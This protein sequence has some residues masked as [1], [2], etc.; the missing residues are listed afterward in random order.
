MSRDDLTAGMQTEVQ[1][2]IIRPVWI[3]RLDIVGD[4]VLA[5]TG[6][7]PFSPVGTGD[8]ALDGNTFVGLGNLGK[9]S[10]IKDEEKGSS[11][12]TLT[13]PGVDLNLEALRQVVLNSNT[14]QFR[15][16]WIWFGLLNET[17]GVI[18]NPTRLKT[19]RIDQMLVNSS[20]DEGSVSVVLESFQSYAAQP[21]M[22]RYVEQKEI[23]ATDKSQ[24]FVHDL[25]NKQPGV[26]KRTT[27]YGGG[28][29]TLDDPLR[30]IQIGF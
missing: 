24:D 23:D 21:L 27:Y 18:N 22:S 5:W 15:Q 25:A 28:T 20:G 11:A 7:G 3:V 26:G 4:P 16:A 19:G 17:L 10:E 2:E 6:R 13:L 1:K 29:P 30:G 14:W 12:V 8:G 9:I